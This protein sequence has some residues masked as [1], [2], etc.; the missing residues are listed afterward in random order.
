MFIQFKYLFLVLM[1][2][3][4]SCSQPDKVGS[5]SKKTAVLTWSVANFSKSTISKADLLSS[6]SGQKLGFAITSISI[7][8]GGDIAEVSGGNLKIHKPGIFSLNLTLQKSGYHDVLLRGCK[9]KITP[10][11][12]KF[13]TL[14][15]LKFPATRS[16]GNTWDTGW[17]ISNINKRPDLIYK[18]YNNQ[19]SL[20]L[21]LASSSRESD[22]RQEDLPITHSFSTFTEI[23]SN[24]ENT[25][26]L[27][28]YD[29][30]SFNDFM[31]DVKFSPHKVDFAKEGVFTSS[32]GKIQVKIFFVYELL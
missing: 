10:Y 28:D 32:D 14:H 23:S 24:A 19:N 3:C 8:S 18:I 5:D 13:K 29:T 27:Y 4:F 15:I 1:M 11:K 6:V 17:F 9:V 25:F 2:F 7:V 30:T 12:T 20:V 21:Q 26:K 31:G 22:A 16:N